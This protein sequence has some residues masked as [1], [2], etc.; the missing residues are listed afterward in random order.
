M[1]PENPVLAIDTKKN[2]NKIHGRLRI[3][4][5]LIY[6]V[7]GVQCSSVVFFFIPETQP[8]YETQAGVKFTNPP[9]MFP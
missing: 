5:T 8:C 7:M 9:V 1:N 4:L 6:K 3:V 2:H